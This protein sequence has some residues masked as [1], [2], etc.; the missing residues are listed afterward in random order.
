MIFRGFQRMPAHLSTQ[1]DNA[2]ARF[3]YSQFD[4]NIVNLTII[5]RYHLRTV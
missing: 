5:L 3:V 1:D 2:L 4:D